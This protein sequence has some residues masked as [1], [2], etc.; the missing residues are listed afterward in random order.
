MLSS[1]EIGVSG[2]VVVSKYFESLSRN[3]TARHAERSWH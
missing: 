2:K 3:V 1:L